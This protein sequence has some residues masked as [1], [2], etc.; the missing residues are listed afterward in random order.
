MTNLRELLHTNGKP[1]T[2]TADNAFYAV[3]YLRCSR[4]DSDEQAQ[5][6]DIERYAQRQG[7]MIARASAP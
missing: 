4:D 1:S 7:V 2:Q 5:R 3:A 6:A